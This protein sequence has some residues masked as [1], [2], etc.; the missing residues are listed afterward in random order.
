LGTDKFLEAVE[1]MREHLGD[2]LS[3][4]IF[5]KVIRGVGADLH[6]CKVVLNELK[7]AKMHSTSDS[8]SKRDGAIRNL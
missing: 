3:A 7:K 4:E 5:S 8:F 2:G 6:C 1:A